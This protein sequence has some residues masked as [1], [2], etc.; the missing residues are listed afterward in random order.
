MRKL[1]ILLC[2]IPLILNGT[3]YHTTK[4]GSNSNPGT[5]ARPFLTIQYGVN[6][7]RA[8]DTLFVHDGIYSEKVNVS[9]YNGT[10]SDP[11]V[12]TNYP[13][14]SPVIDGT[15]VDCGGDG[16]AFVDLRAS[17]IKF[18]GFE[19]RDIDI[20]DTYSDGYA[21]FMNGYNTV[22]NC[23]VHNANK[24]G[25]LLWNNYN[26]LEYSTIYE[27]GMH[28]SNGIIG[29]GNAWGVGLR[30]NTGTSTPCYYNTI[31]HCT[32][33]TIWGETLSTVY[34]QYSTIEDNIVYQ[35]G[36]YLCNSQHTLV[37]R[38]IVYMTDYEAMGEFVYTGI[39]AADEYE[40][41][42]NAYHAIINNIVYGNRFNYFSNSMTNYLVANNVFMNAWDEFGVLIYPGF[43]H[44]NSVFVNNIIIQEDASPVIYYDND[45]GITFSHNLWNKTPIAAVQGTGDI[46]TTTHITREGVFTSPLYYKLL[47]TSPAINAGTDVNVDYDF[48]GS[49]RTQPDIGAWEF[50][51]SLMKYIVSN[52]KRVTSNGKC[53]ALMGGEVIPEPEDILVTGINVAGAGGATTISVQAG[54]LQMYADVSPNNATD[55]TITWSRTNG[56]GTGS[57]NA[58]GLLTALIDGTVTARATANDG[59]AV[60]GT[61]QI[62]ISNQSA[63]AQIIADHTIVDR[64]DD[65]PSEYITE[66]KKMWAVYAG[67]SHSYAIRHGMAL[68]EALNG[69]YNSNVRESGTPDAYTTANLRFSGGTYG[70]YS[71]ASGW[72]YNYGEEDWFT[73]S[74]ALSRTKAGLLYCYNNSLTVAAFGFGWCWDM[75]GL[76]F[77]DGLGTADPVYGNVWYGISKMGPQGDRGWGLDDADN[78]I[79]A[80]TIN[81]DT[82]LEATQE[83]IDY[84]TANSIPTKVFFTTGTVDAIYGEAGYGG[85]LKNERIR[86]YVDAGAT[87]ILFDYADILCYDDN[88]TQTTT[89]WNGHT[90]PRITPTNMG[91]PPDDH[92]HIDD[93]GCLRLAKAMWWM[94]ARIAGWDGN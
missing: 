78:A 91:A 60:Y 33:H 41:N 35:G 45:G 48:G 65:M 61:K 38:N 57:I 21:I 72:I 88:G 83:Y 71:N 19:V 6:Q 36:I 44:S 64:Y 67:E 56:T 14:D 55:T 89:S 16:Y 9:G 86:N 40:G 13:Y 68:L 85:Y 39:G 37:Q 82:Y 1:L 51:T 52:D 84:C 3:T 74:T 69:T 43:S 76:S 90:Y 54:T 32:V 15:G 42:T 17:Y 8:G 24:A 93:P 4:S 46:T 20:E 25:I 5:L 28:N 29:G 92:G 10:V 66:V 81:L 11:I 63:P 94:L 87:R 70:D 26:T 27:C 7:L 58:S 75:V 47:E 23:I 12:I 49:T 80:N 22:S 77:M 59:S 31:R 53:V 34:S 73:N 79:T 30:G 18:N 2:L 62:T 50:G